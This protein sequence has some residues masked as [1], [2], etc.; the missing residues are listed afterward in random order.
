MLVSGRVLILWG[1]TLNSNTRTDVFCFVWGGRKPPDNTTSSCCCCWGAIF[2]RCAAQCLQICSGWGG[3]LGVSRL[4]SWI[5]CDFVLT[6]WESRNIPF[7]SGKLGTSSTQKCRKWEGKGDRSQE[8][9]LYLT[10]IYCKFHG[11][12]LKNTFQTPLVSAN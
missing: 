1:S 3:P 4:W 7:Q 11:C 10:F 2:F 9:Y 8:G 6:C 5:C 12:F